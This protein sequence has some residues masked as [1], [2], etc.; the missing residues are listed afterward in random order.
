M[1][2]EFMKN[3]KSMSSFDKQA[4]LDMEMIERRDS[5]LESQLIASKSINNRPSE[6]RLQ[7][8]N[9]VKRFDSANYFTNY[10]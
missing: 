1:V 4:F 8:E 3:K 9:T 5:R 6:F 7:G 10:N 2:A